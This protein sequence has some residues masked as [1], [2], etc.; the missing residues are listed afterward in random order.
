VGVY[1]GSHQ[2]YYDMAPFFDKI[3][4]TYHG[5]KPTDKHI[6]SMDHTLL[7]C[8]DFPEDEHKMINSVRIRVARNMADYPLGT[9]ISREHR[10]EVEAKIVEALES[11]EGDLKGKYY[12]LASM[13]D[14]ERDQLIA[15]HFLF[16][17]GDKYLESCGLEREWPEARG[18]FHNDAKTFLVW[19]NEED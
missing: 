19:V 2:C 12:S 13:S 14:E 18:I 11:F 4:E 3:I 1:A 7:K 6:S 5:H 16:K 9:S 10:L 15:D 8:P 17:G